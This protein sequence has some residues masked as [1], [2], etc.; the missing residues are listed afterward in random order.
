MQNYRSRFLV[1]AVTSVAYVSLATA[2]PVTT[3][4]LAGRTI[5]YNNGEKATYLRGGKYVNSKF[6]NGTWAVTAAGVQ[7]HAGD[8]SGIFDFEVQP[9]RTI[10]LPSVNLTGTDCK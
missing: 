9:D 8:F 5:C 10:S 7:L 6:G 1:A 3:A 2:K 4:D